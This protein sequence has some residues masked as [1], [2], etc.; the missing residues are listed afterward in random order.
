MPQLEALSAG[1]KSGFLGHEEGPEGE[2]ETQTDP[3]VCAKQRGAG[4]WQLF[5]AEQEASIVG[6]SG[7][8][9]LVTFH[10]R[11]QCSHTGEK[12]RRERNRS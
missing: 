8:T 11:R 7:L 6:A 2:R 9:S 10:R 1:E 4:T 5:A 12:H 3:G